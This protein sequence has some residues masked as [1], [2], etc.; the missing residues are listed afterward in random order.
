[1]MEGILLPI[2]GEGNRQPGSGSGQLLGW[3][4]FAR[5]RVWGRWLD[6]IGCKKLNIWPTLV[7]RLKTSP[8]WS[9]SSSETSQRAKIE[10]LK[11]GL[12][13]QPGKWLNCVWAFGVTGHIKTSNVCPQRM[14]CAL[15]MDPK[16][17]RYVMDQNCDANLKSPKS[18]WRKFRSW[19]LL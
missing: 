14:Y 6:Q 4:L 3:S 8:A 9:R 10:T 5:P 13:F 7:K 16:K 11:I 19:H 15:I 1:M 17:S 2:C 12:F 18:I